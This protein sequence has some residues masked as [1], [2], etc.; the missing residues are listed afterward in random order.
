MFLSIT[1]ISRS[2]KLFL[3][4]LAV[5][6]LIPTAFSFAAEVKV[7]PA[8]GTYALGQTFTIEVQVAP[9]GDSVNAVEA[10]LQF[11]PAILSVVTI[12]KEKSEFSRWTTEP[13]YSNSLGTINFGGVGTTPFTSFSNLVSITFRA[14]APGSGGLSVVDASVF[15]TD[16]LRTDVYSGAVPATFTVNSSASS[17]D[18]DLEEDVVDIVD[19]PEAVS[20]EF[21][22]QEVWYSVTEGVF[23]WTP[24]AGTEAVAVEITDML[25]NKPNNNPEAIYETPISEFSVTSDLLSEGAQ[26]FSLRFRDEDGWGEVLNH[27]ILIDTIAPESFTVMLDSNNASGYPTL[28]FEAVDFTS[29][30]AGYE[31]A[32]PGKESVILTVADAKSGYLFQ[33][34]EDGRYNVAVTAF[35]RAGNVKVSNI[36]VEV[37]AVPHDTSESMGT[38]PN[39]PNLSLYLLVTI[40]ILLLIH[41]YFERKHMQMKEAKLRKETHEVQE[42]TEKIFSALRDEIYEQINTISKRKRLSKAEKEAVDGLNQAI[43]VS[44]TLIAKE[45]ND[46]KKVLK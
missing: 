23:A 8:T 25:D 5:F 16:G 33:E 6:F 21:A 36:D 30:I 11:D 9:G 35:D 18:T 20:T 31:I 38:F 37:T 26:Y 27:K 24:P 13:T 43:Q 40:V 1:T 29:G 39:I 46:V 15:A 7:E 4:L 41:S 22:D 44:E 32:V 42:Q 10:S 19:V 3:A 28:R 14:L 2:T 45:V 12:N 17:S 34:I